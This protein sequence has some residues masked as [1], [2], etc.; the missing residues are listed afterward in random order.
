MQQ[1]AREYQM[2]QEAHIRENNRIMEELGM[3]GLSSAL[4]S[5]SQ[6]NNF[7]ESKFWQQ[8]EKVWQGCLSW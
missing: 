3:S 1:E 5:L 6:K 7:K 2:Q 4:S 8:G